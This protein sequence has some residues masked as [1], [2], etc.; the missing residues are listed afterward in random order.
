MEALRLQGNVYKIGQGKVGLIDRSKL[1]DSKVSLIPSSRK[2]FPALYF[3]VFFVSAIAPTALFAGANITVT[4]PATAGPWDVS[5]NPAF[6]YNANRNYTAPVVVDSGS[7]FSFAPGSSIT[8]RYL[9]GL[10]YCG[11]GPAP[12][13][14]NGSTEVVNDH[15]PWWSNGG[16][17]GYYMNPGVPNYS[18]ELVGTFANNGVIVGQ[19]FA[20]GNGPAT[21]TVPAGANQLQLGIND[22]YNS[23]NTG[24]L[25]VS[26]SQPSLLCLLYDSTKVAQG[27][28]TIP[29]KLQLCDASGNN[30]SSSA[31]VL[32]AT[33]VTQVST[34]ITGPVESPGNANPDSDFRFDSALG[35]TGGYIFNL[36]TRG[37]AT[38]KYN[39]NFTVTGDSFG[40]AA[41]FQV[42]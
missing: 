30:L 12:T 27:G 16:F 11:S 14:A 35:I 8:V 36:S 17:P 6:D 31:I 7:G 10:I 42:K 37:L 13:D 29:I 1:V 33:G 25:T 21:F 9:S 26:V 38:G 18:C 24:S 5:L 39:L 41:P 4:V 22:N 3:A 32:H 2:A 23:D 19:P 20:I 28:S 40:Y 34:S 15:G